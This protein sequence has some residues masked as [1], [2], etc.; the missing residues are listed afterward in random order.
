LS[1]EVNSNIT[2]SELAGGADI[3]KL[4]AGKRL[5]VKTKNTTYTIE[6]REDGFYI[7]GNRKYC[8]VP[9]KCHINGSTWGGSM[10]KLHWIGIGMYM[11]FII[12]MPKEER[13]VGEVDGHGRIVTSQIQEVF[14]L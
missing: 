4:E 8:P 3:T 5:V 13:K 11:E 1:D 12:D 10:L 9:T 2:E 6:H 14:E 7:W